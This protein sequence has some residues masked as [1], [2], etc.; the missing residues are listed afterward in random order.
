MAAFW[1]CSSGW[2]AF[3]DVPGSP[4]FHERPSEL[5]EGWKMNF[6]CI[7]AAFV[8]VVLATAPA[9]ADGRNPGSLLVYPEFDSTR[10]ERRSSP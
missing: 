9:H 1:P 4:S 8:G 10:D 2:K 7:A 5:G 3:Q 6:R